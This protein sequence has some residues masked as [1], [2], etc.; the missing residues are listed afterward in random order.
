MTSPP[1]ISTC[2]PHCADCRPRKRSSA[3]RRCSWTRRALSDSSPSRGLSPTGSS[4][5]TPMARRGRSEAPRSSPRLS[6]AQLP[7]HVAGWDHAQ[8][9]SP[10]PS[11]AKSW[12]ASKATCSSPTGPRPGRSSGREPVSSE[13]ARTAGQRRA[14][15]LVEMAT[16][17]RTAPSD[18]RRPH[19]L[20]TIL[21][22]YETLHGRICELS[23]GT[24][25][26]PGS[27]LPWLDEAYFERAVFAPGGRVEVSPTTRLFSGATR[28]AVEVRD[29]ACTHSVL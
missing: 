26:S 14:D 2:S 27:L 21:V 29:R 8:I 11:S 24:A 17:S 28:R 16:R 12:S 4:W 10:V 13:L 20:F 23:S 5:P 6:R 18:G 22:G 3:T 7:G 1:P 19:P 25:I 15:A 9:P